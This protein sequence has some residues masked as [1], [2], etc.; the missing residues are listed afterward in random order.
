RYLHPRAGQL[1]LPSLPI[2]QRTATWLDR[3][4][5]GAAAQLRGEQPGRIRRTL[6]LLSSLQGP[7]P[8]LRR[9]GEGVSLSQRF[10]RGFS[11]RLQ[12]AQTTWAHADMAAT[13]P[14]GGGTR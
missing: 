3:D 2:A 8:T 1:Q 11:E 6:T 10:L 4:G 7:L 5:R 12:S 14:R 9:K 13:K